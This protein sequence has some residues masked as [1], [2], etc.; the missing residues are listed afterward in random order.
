MLVDIV[1]LPCAR[2]LGRCNTAS[3]ASQERA[4]LQ[5]WP[6]LQF[7][8][9]GLAVQCHGVECGETAA[10][11]HAILYVLV[12]RL[13]ALEIEA[14]NGV[15]RAIAVDEIAWRKLGYTH[16]LIALQWI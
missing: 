9:A 6:G 13:T 11:T 4:R 7:Q 16:I 1:A 8:P 15:D 14:S 12:R 5:I 3:L 2:L 10:R